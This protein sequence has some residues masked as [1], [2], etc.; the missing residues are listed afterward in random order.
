VYDI[1]FNRHREEWDALE[2]RG[3]GGPTPSNVVDFPVTPP[4]HVAT[5]QVILRDAG[6]RPGN[7][8]STEPVSPERASHLFLRAARIAL[9]KFLAGEYIGPEEA[10]YLEALDE[11]RRQGPKP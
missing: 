11:M 1:P 7:V 4:P 2:G 9:R 6:V 10:H 3:P 5:S 8:T